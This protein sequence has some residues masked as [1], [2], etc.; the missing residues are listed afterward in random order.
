MSKLLAGARVLVVD[1]EPDFLYLLESFLADAGA[2]I[3]VARGADEALAALDKQPP[4][5]IVSDISMP[6]GDGYQLMRRIRARPPERGG[7]TPAIALTARI[8][9]TDHSRSLLAGFQLRLCKPIKAMELV[10][11]IHQLLPR[12]SAS[13]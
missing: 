4:D 8:G 3:M 5:V 2:S 10:A 13:H 6:D 7:Q 9:D 1:D 12:R 11:S